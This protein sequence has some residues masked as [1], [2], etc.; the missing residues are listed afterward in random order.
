MSRRVFVHVGTPKSG[1]TYLQAV[2]WHNA[3]ALKAAGLLL[4]G[5]FQT[6]YAAAK[7]VTSRRRMHRDIRIDMDTAWSRLAQQV[8]GW[9]QDALISHELLAPA[10]AEQATTAL[11]ALQGEIHI[12][13]TARALHKQV[14]ASWQEQ[15]KGGMSTTYDA[16]LSRVRSD[17]AKGAWFWDVQHLSGIADRWGRGLPKEHVHVLTVPAKSSEP[18]LLWSRYAT[19]LGLDPAAYDLDVPPKNVSLGVVASELLR[20]VHAVRDYRFTDGSRHPWT[21]KLLAAEVLS[22]HSSERILTPPRAQRWLAERSA[23]MVES[24]RDREYDVCGSLEDLCWQEPDS[25]ARLLQSV[26]EAE[27]ST[28]T[29]WTSNELAAALMRRHPAAALPPLEPAAGIV[30]ILELLEHIRAADTG[31]VPRPAQSAAAAPRMTSGGRRPLQEAAAFAARL[32]PRK[33][34]S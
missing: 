4:P 28:A 16:F 26:T 30:N 23:A 10:S 27:L 24:L 19:V 21:R 13:L 15:V 9:P 6:H 33:P 25:G 18:A 5:R 34:P 3:D 29:A 17:Q 11:N 31:T 22:R 7:G 12:V 14:P 32:R 2:L 8:N 20:R 1:T